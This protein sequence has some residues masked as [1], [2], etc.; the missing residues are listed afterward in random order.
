MLDAGRG[1]LPFAL[2]HGE[3]LVACAAWA[4]G[5]AGFEQVD[6]T[7]RWSSLA[8]CEATVVLH[9]PLCPLTPP[10]FLTE[11]VAL[12][13]ERDAAVVGVRP[14]TDTV[15]TTDPR[16][17][18]TLDVLDRDDLLEVV[19]PLVLPPRAMSTLPGPP[20]TVAD[21]IGLVAGLAAE[22]QVH[23]LL[24]PPQARRLADADGI[25]S[26]EALSPR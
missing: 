21:L 26:L 3:P 14:V 25:A 6:L 11:A 16:S 8:E 18:T 2:V 22:H 23:P 10:G 24:A 17:A 1:S 13:R 4:L 12:S 9:D 15:V 20:R 19:S 7:V 5:E